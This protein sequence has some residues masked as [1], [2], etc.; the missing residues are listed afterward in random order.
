MKTQSKTIHKF[1]WNQPRCKVWGIN[2]DIH[3][4]TGKVTC[5]TCLLKVNEDML[6]ELLTK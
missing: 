5:E 4:D 2:E 1:Q 6:I 3:A